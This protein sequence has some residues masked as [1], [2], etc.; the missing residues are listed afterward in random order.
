MEDKNLSQLLEELHAE[1][2]KTKAV[3]DKGRELLRDLKADIQNLLQDSE[4]AGADD[5]MLERLE[6]SI[7]HFEE[8]HPDLT[9]MLSNLINAL[10]NAGI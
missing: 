6:D 10:N 8:S 2:A 3:D 7:D 1:L 4:E 5:S 9:S